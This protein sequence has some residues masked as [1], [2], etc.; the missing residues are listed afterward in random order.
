MGF[1]ANY[2]LKTLN[3]LAF[4]DSSPSPRSVL[5]KQLRSRE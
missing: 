1:F 5:M 3:S 4:I 2:G